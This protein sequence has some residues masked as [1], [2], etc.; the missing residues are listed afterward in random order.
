MKTFAVQLILIVINIT[1]L[2]L[3]AKLPSINSAASILDYIKDQDDNFQVN[4]EKNLVLVFGRDASETHTLTSLITGAELQSIEIENGFRVVDKTEKISNVI[5]NLMIDERD[6]VVF[7]ECL[8]LDSKNTN[9]DLTAT[10][11]IRKLLNFAESVKFLYT[12]PQSTIQT[13]QQEFMKLLQYA[14]ELIR[15]VQK[16]RDGIALAVTKVAKNEDDAT[17]IES[18]ANTLREIK[19]ELMIKIPETVADEQKSA[20]ERKI[21]FI[22]TLLEK[23][24]NGYTKIGVVR[25]P[26]KVGL[27]SEMPL[28]QT[29]KELIL[30]MVNDNLRYIQTEDNDFR[31]SIS[32]D[33]RAH[34]DSI[35]D[36]LKVKLTDS[37]TIISSDIRKFLLQ[38]EKHNS[39]SL[40]DSMSAAFEIDQQLSQITSMEPM[41]FTKQ[42][43]DVVDRLG[44]SLFK[45]SLTKFLSYIEIF[46]FIQSFSVNNLALPI[47][48]HNQIANQ[49]AFLG[50]SQAFYNF[51]FELREKLS[52]YSVLHQSNIHDSGRLTSLV[53]SGDNVERTISDLDIQTAINAVDRQMYPRIQQ[54][55]VNTFK[56]KLLRAVWGQS[57][58]PTVID[59]LSD[60][61]HLVAV[62]YNVLISDVMKSNCWQNATNIEIYSLNKI[63][64]DADINQAGVY[65]SIISPVWDV[66]LDN[67]TVSRLIELSG[68]NGT[69]YNSPARTGTS[70]PLRNDQLIL[71]RP[72]ETLKYPERGEHGQPGMP[73]GPGGQ[74]FG[75]GRIIND[76][77]L[78]VRVNGGKG[79][80]GQDGGRGLDGEAGYEVPVSTDIKF[81]KSLMPRCGKIVDKDAKTKTY[82]FCG[83]KGIPPTDGGN[84]GCRGI[85]GNP[86]HSHIF[87][88]EN[89]SN[90]VEYN[91]KGWFYKHFYLVI[92]CKCDESQFI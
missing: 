42:L 17:N 52:S 87:G 32:D 81:L 34:V 47:E 36:E 4:S 79:G 28:I 15:D 5:P 61:K 68:A 31:Y 9:E 44:I 25:H 58:Q 30:N 41:Q 2:P 67:S 71:A 16:Y 72:R 63:F 90:I 45:G 64:F 10:F 23:N 3:A 6:G 26:D 49:R 51:L 88:L 18:I 21:Q 70:Y 53:I 76:K 82:I 84:G 37:F 74:L 56:L 38:K 22:D 19:T 91:L 46:D 62:G 65:L 83:K 80:N 89:R 50:N 24:E 92:V 55:R 1:A 66:V 57:T 69:N 78:E 27:L 48:I 20:I 85:G 40:N 60:G 77:R 35:A 12:V 7:Y 13:N 33:S 43:T 8:I 73:G 11:A 86:G 75:I 39:N 29:E 59:C 54:L 14:T